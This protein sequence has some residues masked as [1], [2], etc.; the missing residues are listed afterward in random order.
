[1][2]VDCH[3][4]WG[5]VWEER[6]HSD[7]TRWLSA[8][9][10][11]GIRAAL[12]YGH[13]NLHRLDW[14]RKD[15]DLL[16]RVAA[17]APDRIVPIGTSWLQTGD[18][19]VDEA[20]RCLEELGMGGLKFHPWLQGMSVCHPLMDRI[21]ELAARHDVPIF[22]HDGTPP[23]SNSEQIAA[24]ALRNPR[25]SIVLG[26]SGLLWNW[27]SALAFADVS[28]LFFCL[29]GPP[30]RAVEILCQR[31]A[32][33][34]MVWGSDFGFGVADAIEYRLELLRQANIPGDLR[35]RILGDNAIRLVPAL[36][37]KGIIHEG[38]GLSVDG[39]NGPDG[40]GQLHSLG[41]GRDTDHRELG[42]APVG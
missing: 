31:V 23:Y 39:A 14:C 9:D 1:V 27:R 35:A 41:S 29:C 34:R 40:H 32:P 20:R 16:A 22:F 8:L 42:P 17:Q 24:L 19:A 15:N 21:C 26:H 10:G 6:D 37:R 7:P 2:I 18:E 25:T 33:E 11:Q 38:Y 36:R 28:N 12:L 13:A 30:L 5:M 4:H 3:T